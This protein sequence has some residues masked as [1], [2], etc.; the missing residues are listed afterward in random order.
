MSSTQLQTKIQAIKS[1][2]DESYSITEVHFRAFTLLLFISWLGGKNQTALQRGRCARCYIKRGCYS[3]LVFPAAC[4]HSGSTFLT[5]LKENCPWTPF[6]LKRKWTFSTSLIRAASKHN[7][8]PNQ[9]LRTCTHKH[10]RRT[11][12]CHV[13]AVSSRN[14]VVLDFNSHQSHLITWPSH[15]SFHLFYV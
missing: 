12:R 14:I 11:W 5:G 13:S 2:H 4:S 10:L 1:H 8:R 7:T 9:H 15:K 6:Y 3:S